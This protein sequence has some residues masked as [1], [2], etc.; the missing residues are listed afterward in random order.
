MKKVVPKFFGLPPPKVELEPTFWNMLKK[1]FTLT[2]V[3]K[4]VGGKEA[5]FVYVGM[6]E[7]D[8]N[9]L[10]KIAQKRKKLSKNSLF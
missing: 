2:A 5:P 4:S 7:A 6:D 9:F 8:G 1:P 3:H 10:K